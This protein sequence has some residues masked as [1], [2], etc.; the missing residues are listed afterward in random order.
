[1]NEISLKTKG[2]PPREFELLI[3]GHEV[4]GISYLKIEMFPGKPVTLD[5]RFFCTAITA[6]GEHAPRDVVIDHLEQVCKCEH[7]YHFLPTKEEWEKAGR[8]FKDG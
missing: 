3:D 7:E 1:M 2:N 4:E 6:E 5:L 8:K